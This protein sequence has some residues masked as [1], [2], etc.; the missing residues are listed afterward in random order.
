MSGLQEYVRNHCRLAKVF[1]AKVEADTR[2][3]VMNDVKVSRN[4]QIC[5]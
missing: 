2:F 1:E 3:R 4:I 5:N